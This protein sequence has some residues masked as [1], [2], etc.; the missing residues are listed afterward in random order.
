MLLCTFSIRALSFDDDAPSSSLRDVFRL[1]CVKLEIKLGQNKLVHVRT[2]GGVHIAPS[3][4]SILPYFLEDPDEQ[5]KQ[6]HNSLR[7]NDA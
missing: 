3:L 7:S 4:C 1:V 6:F 5:S 2:M